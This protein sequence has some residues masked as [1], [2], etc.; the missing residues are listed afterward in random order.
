MHACIFCICYVLSLFPIFGLLL[1]RHLLLCL[2]SKFELL[3]NL[4][5]SLWSATRD[6]LRPVHFSLFDFFWVW[7]VCD[8][9]REEKSLSRVKGWKRYKTLLHKCSDR[10]NPCVNWFWKSIFI[11]FVLIW[12]EGFGSRPS[13]RYSVTHLIHQERHF[14]WVI[15]VFGLLKG[16]ALLRL[17]FRLQPF[18]PPADA[19]LSFFP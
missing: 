19:T 5:L 8:G 15:R 3:K 17:V 2:Y 6:A 10:K 4:W 11:W 13:V 9:K 1:L 16:F 12:V 14:L 18:C 7:Q